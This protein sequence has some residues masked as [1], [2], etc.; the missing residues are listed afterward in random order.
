[1]SISF[2]NLKIFDFFTNFSPITHSAPWAREEASQD[3][4][5]SFVAVQQLDK[6]PFTYRENLAYVLS[7]DLFLG[8]EIF[9]ALIERRYII[10]DELLSTPRSV[11]EIE[12]TRYQTSDKDIEKSA[13]EIQYKIYR[14]NKEP[15]NV[16]Y[17]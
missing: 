17:V 6:Y 1:M 16:I 13:R 8:T 7:M 4:V 5:N 11:K 3:Q 12:K 2:F 10:E 15:G 14:N 9:E